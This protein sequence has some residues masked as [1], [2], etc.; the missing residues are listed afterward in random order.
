[1]LNTGILAF[2]VFSDDANVDVLV[3]CFDTGNALHGPHVG[4]KVKLLP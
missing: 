4:I 1:M 2:R 3:S